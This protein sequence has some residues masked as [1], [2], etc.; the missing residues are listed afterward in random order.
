MKWKNCK[1]IAVAVITV[2][3]ENFIFMIGFAGLVCLI[4]VFVW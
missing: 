2:L 1:K 4:N 3:V